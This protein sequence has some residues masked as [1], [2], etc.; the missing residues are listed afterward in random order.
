MRSDLP[1]APEKKPLPAES[2]PHL[3]IKGMGLKRNGRWLFRDLNWDVPRGSV[4]AVVGPSG[5]GKSSLLNCLAGLAE[6][7]EGNVT[8][9]CNAG[10]LH[11]ASNYQKR[12]G[13]IFQNL[14]LSQNSSVLRNVLCG[15]LGRYPWWRTLFRFP[16]A[17]KKAATLLLTDL[18]LSTQ[19]HR[20]AA[21]TSGGEQQRAAIARA[22][23]QEPELLLADEP[24]SNLDS[25]LCGRVLGILR[26]Q[27]HQHQRTAF[28]VLHDP[29]LLERFADYALSIDPTNPEKWRVREVHAAAAN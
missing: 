24:V 22:L 1:L 10:C 17:D 27:A 25:H 21:D 5:V 13:I 3:S 12:V 15:R 23:F 20:R 19:L 8:F 2:L 16:Q 26:E 6:P 7:T 14:L 18:G 11:N 9:S 28:C 4:V 29:A